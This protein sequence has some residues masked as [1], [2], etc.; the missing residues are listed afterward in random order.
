MH[1]ALTQNQYHRRLI[2]AD[3][4]DDAADE[5]ARPMYRDRQKLVEVGCWLTTVCAAARMDF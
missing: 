3:D 5:L 4:D 1:S 2:D